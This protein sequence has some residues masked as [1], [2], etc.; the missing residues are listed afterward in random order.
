M[1]QIT[2]NITVNEFESKKEALIHIVFDGNKMKFP[3][4]KLNLNGMII[5]YDEYEK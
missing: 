2:E 3:T 1:T 5:S 4:D